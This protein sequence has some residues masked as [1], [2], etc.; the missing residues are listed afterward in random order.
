MTGLY[1]QG[2]AVDALA[3]Y[4]EVVDQLREEL[5]LEPGP[6]L[7][8]L[9][10]AIL[11]DAPVAGSS[12]GVLPIGRADARGD[13]AR[14]ARRRSRAGSATRTAMPC[15]PTGTCCASAF[16]AAP[17]AHR[18]HR[19][20]APPRRLPQRRRRG[21][22]R[23]R[24]APRARPTHPVRPGCG[25]PRADRRAHR[26]APRGRPALRRRRTCTASLQ[27]AQAAAG[28]QTL[29][30]TG[31]TVRHLDP[32]LLGADGLAHHGPRAPPAARTS[33]CPSTSTRVGAD[34]GRRSRRPARSAVARCLPRTDRPLWSVVDAELATLV[35]EATRPGRGAHHAG[36]PGWH[37]QDPA[38]GRG[39]RAR[40]CR[41][42]PGG[43]YFVALEAATTLDEAW[44]A[45]GAA[46]GPPR[47]RARRPGCCRAPGRRSARSSVL[48]NLEQLP[49][50][51]VAVDRLLGARRRT[52][53]PRHLAAP[54]RRG[55]RAAC[56]TLEPL[57]DSGV[58]AERLA[59]SSHRSPSWPGR[60]SR[61]WTHDN[62]DAV[63][64]ICRRLD[65]LPLA[66][67]L[68]AARIATAA[69]RTLWR[70]SSDVGPRPGVGRHRPART[71]SADLRA[72]DGMVAR[73]AHDRAAATCSRSSPSSWAVSTSR[74]VARASRRSDGRR[75]DRDGPRPR[76]GQPGPSLRRRRAR[77]S[78]CWRRSG[79]SRW[80]G[81]R[82]VGPGG[83]G[84][85][86]PS[87]RFRRAGPPAAPPP[88]GRRF[89]RPRVV[90]RER[91]QHRGR[92]RRGRCAGTGRRGVGR[93]HHHRSRRGLA[94]GRRPRVRL[95]RD[96]TSAGM[97]PG[98]PRR[99][100]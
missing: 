91:R 40:R 64:R 85:R 16:S 98:S 32:A 20:R 93:R 8:A 90:R 46:L 9:Q 27:V 77:A 87:R 29:V 42:F 23:G 34:Q 73:P 60:V 7:K 57:E 35:D 41:S 48:D 15:S 33:S 49:E 44:A 10:R 83:R 43:V 37:R 51:A 4:A 79:S 63:A 66:I 45:I 82:R 21:P 95:P 13:G 28:G 36:R 59:S 17:R 31:P 14:L 86:P 80:S 56:T 62:R 67:E 39:G 76:R 5:G 69:H 2:R 75:P 19:R 22:R 12:T 72:L 18:P 6:T 70:A 92:P 3:L 38:G 52:S 11:T 1:R 54:D 58:S 55:R 88:R 81:S 96:R 94:R 24:R 47:R 100:G 30:L 61:S 50:A 99:G 25:R 74:C 65:G 26:H 89:A 78:R 68:A 97:P 53:D 84:P 71:A